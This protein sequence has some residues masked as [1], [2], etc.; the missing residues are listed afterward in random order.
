MLRTFVKS[1]DSTTSISAETTRFSHQ[2]QRLAGWLL[3][4]FFQ[5]ILKSLSYVLKL[6]RSPP[7]LT[8][9]LELYVKHVLTSW[10]AGR[11]EVGAKSEVDGL[12]ELNHGEVL[13]PNSFQLS[14]FHFMSYVSY[15][16]V[17]KTKYSSEVHII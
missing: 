3:S 12:F 4:H 7:R 13:K 10:E 2:N 8:S 11:R 17:L 5:P 6:G 15:F 1:A 9:Y 14:T 16:I